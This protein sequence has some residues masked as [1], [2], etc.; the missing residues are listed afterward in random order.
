MLQRVVR[1]VGEAVD[2]VVV[3]AAA[4]QQLPDLPPE[5]VVVCDR[6]P[7]Q[8]PLEGLAV[9][10]RALGDRAEAA[11]VTACDVPLLVPAF[12]R[13]VVDLLPGFDIA[14][15]HVDGF[16]QPLAACYR[17][18]VLAH[19]ES[20]LERNRLRPAFL[21]KKASTRRITAA[22][23]TDIDP[24]LNSLANVNSPIDY[25]AALAKAGFSL[26]ADGNNA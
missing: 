19:V 24:G 20:L 6:R 7:D 23:L 22:E 1:L 8:G 14:V 21:F 13:R 10:L 18:S 5:I 9:G 3:V 16:D 11:F 17:T 12:V 2:P 26:P 4:G 25:E 15:P